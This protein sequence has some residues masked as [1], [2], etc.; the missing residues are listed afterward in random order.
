M[1][2]WSRRVL[3]VPGLSVLACFG[4][5]PACKATIC[6]GRADGNH[7][8]MGDQKIFI[9]E[10]NQNATVLLGEMVMFPIFVGCKLKKP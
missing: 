3:T 5:Y 1:A 10:D 4:F 9:S 2:Y 7:P 8:S 6:L